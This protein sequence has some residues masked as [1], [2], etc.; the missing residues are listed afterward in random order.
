MS[1]PASLD[2]QLGEM[3]LPALVQKLREY[4]QEHGRPLARVVHNG[5]EV[6]SARND[7][8]NGSES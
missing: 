8:T 6:W 3:D 4:A 2:F 1:E 7:N 5:R